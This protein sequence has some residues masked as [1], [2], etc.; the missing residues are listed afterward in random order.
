MQVASEVKRRWRKWSIIPSCIVVIFAPILKPAPH[1]S[2]IRF[3][4][5][6]L[7]AHIVLRK[8]NMSFSRQRFIRPELFLD[9]KMLNAS[10]EALLNSL[11]LAKLM[12]VPFNCDPAQ[13][14]SSRK[15]KLHRRV[16]C[17]PW[18]ALIDPCAQPTD[19]F[20]RQRLSLSFRRH[21][22]VFGHSRDIINQRTFC[23]VP[24]NNVHSIVPAFERWF[25][26]I[27]PKVALWPFLAV[28]TKA[29]LFENWLYIFF[30]FYSHMP[31]RR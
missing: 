2:K 24:R 13:H 10:S 9:S 25:P 1:K 20:S 7:H 12:F 4:Q 29:A 22:D 28:A 23:A 17:T 19:L 27:Q 18:G 21:L 14:R 6:Q 8:Q 30:Y 11:N 16:R 3:A 5:F 15:S 31:P 26:I